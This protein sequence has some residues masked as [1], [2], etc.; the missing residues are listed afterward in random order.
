[1]EGGRRLA[2]GTVALTVH[3]PSG[4]LDLVVPPEASVDDVAREYAAKAGLQFAPD[5]AQP[6]RARH[7]S[8]G[9]R[10]PSSASAAATCWPPAAPYAGTRATTSRRSRTRRRPA[11]SRSRG[12]RSPSAVAAAGRL[13]RVAGRRAGHRRGPADRRPAR[14]LRLPRGAADRAAQRAPHGGRPGLRGRRGVR[15]GLGAG[16]GAA[17]RRSSASPHWSPRVAA[18]VARALDVAGRRGAAGLDRGG[19]GAV[20]RHRR[21]RAAARGDPRVV[22]AA[23]ARGARWP[24]GSCPASRSTCPTSSSSTSNGWPSTAWSARDRPHGTSRPDGRAAGRGRPGRG[25]R[26]PDRHRLRRR[27]LGGGR[28]RGADAAGHRRPA[29]R[30][31]RRTGHGRPLGRGP[32]AGCSQLPA[33]GG[34]RDAPRRRAHLLGRAGR[35]AAG[36]LSTPGRGSP[37]ASP[38]SCWPSCSSSVAVATGRGWRSAWWSR[39]AEVAEGLAGAGA[40]A[41]LVVASGLFRALWEIKFRV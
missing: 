13:V 22:W 30:P 39:R 29:R 6:A 7:W 4:A 33:P 12:S 35:R 28:G 31:D 27:D 32:A 5:P 9:R 34:A 36:R 23:A 2:H 20:P 14:L 41:A 1:M 10:W 15:G 40:I 16:A 3:G 19:R 11:P 37:W 38:G 25:P 8:P 26:I 24:R 17:A 21:R 18:G